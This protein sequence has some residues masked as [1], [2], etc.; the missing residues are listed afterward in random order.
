MFRWTNCISFSIE[1]SLPNWVFGILNL[2][3]A[4]ISEVL[5]IRV[6]LFF[7]LRVFSDYAFIPRRHFE[8]IL[9]YSF[10]F[11]LSWMEVLF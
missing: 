1:A 2:V 10:N 11:A 3:A 9:M 5:F 4:L 7:A 8:W 6:V